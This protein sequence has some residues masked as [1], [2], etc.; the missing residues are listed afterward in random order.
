MRDQTTNEAGVRLGE[1]AASLDDQ[2]TLTLALHY[3]REFVHVLTLVN[4]VLWRVPADARVRQL[5]EALKRTGLQAEVPAL[6]AS[7]TAVFWIRNLLAHSIVYRE[8]DDALTLFSVRGGQRR[9]LTL[10]HAHLRW[11]VR[12][13]ERCNSEYFALIEGRIGRLDTWA[14]LYGFDE[15]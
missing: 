6:T 7:L 3:G 15:R 8:D 13:A 12:T 5:E 4:D 9:N 14:E 11:A 10:T 1:L 2:L